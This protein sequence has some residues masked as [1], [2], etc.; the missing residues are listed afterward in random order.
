MLDFF[1]MRLVDRKTGQLER[2]ANWREQYTHLNSHFHNCLRITRMLKFFGEVGLE[3]LQ[4]PFV[5]FVLHEIFANHELAT[6]LD[7]CIKYWSQVIRNDKERGVVD[8]YIS[9][10]YKPTDWVN[11]SNDIV[12][13]NI[14]VS[15]R[16]SW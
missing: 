4:A 3:Y 9:K 10:H 11:I 13:N 16:T 15:T 12:T 2:G 5:T 6:C 14:L 1:G 7:S 8:E